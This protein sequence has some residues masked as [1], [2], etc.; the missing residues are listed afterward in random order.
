MGRHLEQALHL[1]EEIGLKDGPSVGLASRAGERFAS[2]GG[3]AFAALDLITS[4]D[5]L[6]RAEA[7]LP[8]RSAV[9]LNLLPNLGVALTETGRPSE[10]EFLLT[11]A[12]GQ[13]RAAG[14]EREALR[15]LI[16]LQSNR[17]YRSPTETEIGTALLETQAAADALQEMGDD[18]GLAEAAI[19]IEYLE[20][21]LGRVAE[22]YAWT[23]RGLEHG[24]SAKRTREAAQAAADLVWS[25]V[26]VLFL[27]TGSQRS[28]PRYPEPTTTRSAPQPQ[29]HCALWWSFARGQWVQLPPA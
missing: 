8:E 21:M 19:A 9:R 7:L 2:A 25:A 11:K 20:W 26:A 23:F 10:T 15:A 29:T 12:I 14:S 13:A 1:R 24:L 6:G 4:R 18:V 16:Q 22:A 5:L 28:P 3:R 17:V 27:S